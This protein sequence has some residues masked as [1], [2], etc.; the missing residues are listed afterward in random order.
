MR[1][2]RSDDAAV[3]PASDREAFPAAAGAFHVGVDEGKALVQ[4]VTLK[5]NGDATQLFKVRTGYHH[6]G[7]VRFEHRVVRTHRVSVIEGVG[8]A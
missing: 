4:T 1:P 3:A 8:P 5:I 7:I 2:A 6:L